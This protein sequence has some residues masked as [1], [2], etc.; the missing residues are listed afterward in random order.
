MARGGDDVEAVAL[1][2]VVGA[3]GERELVLA[4]VAGAGVDVADRER[5]PA[6]RRRAGRSGGGDGAGGGAGRTSAVHAGVAE[7]E[8]LVDQR[9]VGQQV[10]GHDVGEHRPVR[11]RAGAQVQ[12]RERGRRAASS[13]QIVAPRGLSTRATATLRA[14]S[15]AGP[16]AAGAIGA[17][18]SS[19][20]RSKRLAQLELALCEAGAHVA[21]RRG[22]SAR[23]RSRRRRASPPAS[24]RASSAMPGAR[25]TG[26]TAPRRDGVVAAEHADAVEAVLERGVEARARA[27]RVARSRS[28]TGRACRARAR[29]S[30]SF[31][32]RG[33]CRR[34]RRCRTGSGA[35]RSAALSR[36]ASSQS[37]AKRWLPAAKPTPAQI[38]AMSLR[39]FQ[40]RSSSSSS[41]RARATSPAGREP[42]QLLDGVCVG[43]A[44]RDRAGGAGAR[45]VGDRRRRSGCP[46]AAR[47]RPRC[48]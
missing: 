19:S 32:R 7:L 16:Q 37:A 43:D 20:S 23:A 12:P 38:A 34:R 30:W 31:E 8:A 36:R 18:S 45:G 9:E 22:R 41:V 15:R 4:A 14:A 46:V 28:Q 2:V 42:A 17:A 1:Q 27:R 3:R 11:V 39:W 13:A 33:G 25:A 48:L 44:V 29:A 40:S 21:R 35:R 5:A 24:V 26:P 47:S 6:R 10:A